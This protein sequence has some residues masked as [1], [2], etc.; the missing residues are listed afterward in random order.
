VL[1]KK[2]FFKKRFFMSFIRAGLKFTQ[3]I[4]AKLWSLASSLLSF[5]F[6]SVNYQAPSWMKWCGS[7]LN[8]LRLAMAQKPI[9]GVVILALIAALGAGGWQGWEWYK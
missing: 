6:G 2:E 5:F 4:F 8:D 7:K 9:K 3:T 1:Y